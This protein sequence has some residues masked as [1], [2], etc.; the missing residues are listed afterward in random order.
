VSRTR[1]KSDEGNAN[2]YYTFKRDGGFQKERSGWVC[3]GTWKQHGNQ[4]VIKYRW[5]NRRED[6]GTFTWYGALDG[7]QIMFRN[8]EGNISFTVYRL[9]P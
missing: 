1:W 4:V 5:P 6:D 3:N 9:D 2:F 7:N 8:E